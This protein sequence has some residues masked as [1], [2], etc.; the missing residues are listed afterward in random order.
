MVSILLDARASVESRCEDGRSALHLATKHPTNVAKLLLGARAEVNLQANDGCTP[1]HDAVAENN[2]EIIAL[3]I[4]H[5][6]SL[7][8]KDT[9]GRTA[10]DLAVQY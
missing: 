5:Q 6:A 3:L 9:E 10:L 8:A 7:G 2:Q 4:F 1:L